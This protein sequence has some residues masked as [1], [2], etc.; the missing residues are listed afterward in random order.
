[1]LDPGTFQKKWGQL[2]LSLSQVCCFWVLSHAFCDYL[3]SNML[4]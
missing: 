2:A 3:Y 1:V 4:M